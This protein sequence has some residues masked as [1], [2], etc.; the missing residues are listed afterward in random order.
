MASSQAGPANLNQEPDRKRPRHE[1]DAELLTNHPTLYFDDG[2]LILQCHKTLFCVHKSLLSKHSPVFR[3]ILAPGP[4]LLELRGKTLLKLPD[5]RDDMEALLG[6][7]Y[8][9]LCVSSISF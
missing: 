7:I 9:G 1:M 8:D 3:D 5:D 2:N 4:Q 6:T